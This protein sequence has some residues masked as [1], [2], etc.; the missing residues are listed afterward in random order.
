MARKYQKVQALLPEIQRMLDSGMSQREVAEALGLEGDR[1]IHNLLKRERKKNV[2]GMPKQRG[3]KP[4]R[5]LQEYKY[6]NK[7]LKMENEL[8]RDFL[9]LRGKEVRARFKYQVIFRHREAYP[10]SVMCTFFRG[11]PERLLRLCGT[12]AAGPRRMHRSPGCFGSSRS[13]AFTLTAIA[14]CTCGWRNR[15]FIEIRKLFC[16]S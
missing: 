6:E 9:S 8:L 15:A 11:V 13:I 5:T 3:R 14:G 2:Q 10:V 4:A 16:V 12:S 7:R 1:P